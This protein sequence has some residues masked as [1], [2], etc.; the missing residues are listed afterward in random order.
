MFSN[1]PLLTSHK[2]G[3]RVEDMRTL[4]AQVHLRS[5]EF[6]GP[7]EPKIC[8]EFTETHLRIHDESWLYK[9]IDFYRFLD[10]WSCGFQPLP[11]DGGFHFSVDEVLCAQ[12][13]TSPRG[14]FPT[15]LVL[16]ISFPENEQEERR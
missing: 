16:R 8:R 15:Q 5:V 4:F 11:R 2:R 9:L 12:P 6:G 3:L 1:G 7:L 14:L 13:T 10:C